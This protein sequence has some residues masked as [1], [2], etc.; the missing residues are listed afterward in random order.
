MAETPQDYW[1]GVWGQQQP[2]GGFN[3][4]NVF[5]NWDLNPL[6]QQTGLDR[7]A[8]ATQRDAFLQPL[9]QQYRSQAQP[10][11]ADAKETGGADRMISSGVGRLR[12]ETI[13]I[14]FSRVFMP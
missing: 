9:A 2:W 11:T 13:R 1:G 7:D 14:L 3:A 4:Q 6:S 12:C 5:E 10:G 8:L